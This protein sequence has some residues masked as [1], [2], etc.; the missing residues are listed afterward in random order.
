ML[1]HVDGLPVAAVATHLARSL[2]ATEQIL[3]RARAAFRVAYEETN[4]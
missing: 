4:K 2:E 1:R 3:T